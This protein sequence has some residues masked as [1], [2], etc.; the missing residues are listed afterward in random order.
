MS[1]DPTQPQKWRICQNYGALN[2]VTQVF[3]MPQG[4]ICTKQR[5]LSGHR[6]VHG[7]DFASGFYAVMIP[8]ESRPYLAYYVEG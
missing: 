5:R 1:Y 2:K 8:G 4:D 6:W 3:P 7:F